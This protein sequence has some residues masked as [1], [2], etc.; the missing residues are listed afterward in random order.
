MMYRLGYVN[1]NWVGGWKGGMGYWNKIRVD[2]PDVF[3]EAVAI[4]LF[5]GMVAI[6]AGIGSGL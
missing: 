4:T 1:N 6:W 2:F 3:A 5:I